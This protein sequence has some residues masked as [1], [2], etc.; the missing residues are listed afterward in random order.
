MLPSY[1]NQFAKIWSVNEWTNKK[2]VLY[3]QV[4]RFH[5]FWLIWSPSTSANGAFSPCTWLS[6]VL[7]PSW[8]SL[9]YPN[10]PGGWSLREGKRRLKRSFTKSQT[11]IPYWVN[12]A[13]KRLQVWFLFFVRWYKWEVIFWIFFEQWNFYI[14]FSILFFRAIHSP[15][16]KIFQFL[17]NTTHI[18]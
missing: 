10:H 3:S 4:S 18:W 17:F 16:L 7:C 1:Q 2:G 8:R 9:C 14:S 6:P 13:R 5:S 12:I 15:N 11:S